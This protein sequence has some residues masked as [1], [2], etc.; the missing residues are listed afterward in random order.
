MAKLVLF[1][2]TPELFLRFLAYTQLGSSYYAS[3]RRHLVP[4]SEYD[5]HVF[6]N[7]TL[8]L[9]DRSMAIFPHCFT[10]ADEAALDLR[11]VFP[12]V[13]D[14]QFIEL[15]GAIIDMTLPTNYYSPPM[16]LL[17]YAILLQNAVGGHP[18]ASHLFI[19]DCYLDHPTVVKWM[20]TK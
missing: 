10:E 12:T 6:V 18:Y 13:P 17:G 16:E 11:T 9:P 8:F 1:R 4:D 7:D 20:L 2:G 15:E 14:N 19:P 5:N 3:I